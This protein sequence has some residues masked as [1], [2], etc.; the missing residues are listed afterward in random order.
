MLLTERGEMR[1]VKTRGGSAKG[2]IV[3][4]KKREIL[5]SGSLCLTGEVSGGG[6]RENSGGRSRRMKSKK[7]RAR[8]GPAWIGRAV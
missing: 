6:E 3:L 7:G 4:R 1:A 8:K 5:P 2:R